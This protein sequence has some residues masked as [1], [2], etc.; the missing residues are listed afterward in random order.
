MQFV[1]TE[2][3]TTGRCICICIHTGYNNN[4]TQARQ[5]RVSTNFTCLLATLECSFIKVKIKF[6][7][8]ALQAQRI[9]MGTVFSSAKFQFWS[10]QLVVICMCFSFT[11]LNGLLSFV[12]ENLIITLVLCI[13]A[14]DF[15]I[16]SDVKFS[17]SEKL[18]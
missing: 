8:I 5:S 18:I 4:N 11:I 9:R 12:I 1:P 16:R 6:C 2:S 10:S 15:K 7:F 17:L 14:E 13:W 3:R